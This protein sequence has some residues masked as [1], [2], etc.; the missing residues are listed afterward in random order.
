MMERLLSVG[1]AW[2]FLAG[3]VCL[4]AGPAAGGVYD[5]WTRSLDLSL[6]TVGKV[7]TNLAEYPVLVVLTPER[8]DNYAGFAPGGADLRFSDASGRAA[9]SYEIER[10]DP[11]GNSYIWVKVPAVA[12]NTTTN[13]QAHWG[14]PSAASQSNAAAVFSNGYV[15]VWHLN[16]TSGAHN[17]SAG[18]VNN[19]GAA[20]GVVA[21]GGPGLIA[22]ADAFGG[23]YVAIGSSSELAMGSAGTIQAW[24]RMDDWNTTGTSKDILNNGFSYPNADAAYLSQH[25]SVGLHFRYGGGGTDY[26]TYATSKGWVPGSWHHT[27]V[28]WEYTGTTQTTI[29]LFP[30]AVAPISKTVGTRLSPTETAWNISR[31]L[32]GT[33]SNHASFPGSIDEVRISNVA[34]AAD[35]MKAD[36]YSGSDNLIAYGAS[37][38]YY[39]PGVAAKARGY[40]KL[41][42][43]STGSTALNSG[44][45]GGSLDAGFLVNRTSPTT[46][47][48]V[49]AE[50]LV[51]GSTGPNDAA[52]FNGTA[53]D[54]N[55]RWAQG[56]GINTA[57]STGGNVFA[58]EWTIETWF[59]RDAITSGAGIF[60]QHTEIGTSQ[61]LSYRSPI[62]TFGLAGA[63][64]NRL[65]IME[66]GQS[67]TGVFLDLGPDHLNKEVYAVMTKTGT[68]TIN[69]YAKIE[70]EDTWRT[71]SGTIGWALNTS[72]DK[73][74]IGRH[75]LAGGEHAFS[76][77]ID[78][79]AIYDSALDF[80]TIQRNYVM[81]TV[82]EPSTLLLLAMALA[83]L[84]A[85]RRVRVRTCG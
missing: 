29:S 15:G 31:D 2:A 74:L 76:G 6:N 51:L 11:N 58:G 30:D 16:E 47:N 13:I 37:P 52:A 62:L 35:W 24:A 14:M 26:V 82:P 65:G 34:R 72:L 3:A 42:D 1:W 8:T 66:A 36:Y 19:T 22:G 43:P 39:A 23:G 80:A 27:G 83:G 7:G 48:K 17:D 9:L 50:G 21:Q 78:D 67:W 77:T 55:S 46:T 49:H 12:G 10:F 25:N 63:N 18:T 5:G 75:Y 64:E 70:G 81:G 32:D 68:N 40:W 53:G 69:L 28:T 4:V 60:S 85:T 20:S 33:G 41:N 84:A 73:F 38:N 61:S 57:S 54:T 44:L 59:E 71:T 45:A 79:L 56:S